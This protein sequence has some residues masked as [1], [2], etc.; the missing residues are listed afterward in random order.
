[1]EIVAVYHQF[2]KTMKITMKIDAAECYNVTLERG[3]LEIPNGITFYRASLYKAFR[4]LA[5]AWRIYLLLSGKAPT[6]RYAHNRNMTGTSLF[7]QI[8]PAC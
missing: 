5:K 3:R 6:C 8:S 2:S 4:F 1:M 7:V